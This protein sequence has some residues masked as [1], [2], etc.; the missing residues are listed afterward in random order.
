MKLLVIILIIG[1]LMDSTN[2]DCSS[3]VNCPDGKYFMCHDS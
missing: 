1:V 3:S 2:G